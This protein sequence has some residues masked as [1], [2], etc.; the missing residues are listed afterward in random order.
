MVDT[1]HLAAGST[2]GFNIY[3]VVKAYFTDL[4]K[5]KAINEML[6]ITDAPEACATEECFS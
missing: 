3:E 1:L 5:R 4:D 2:D 6:G